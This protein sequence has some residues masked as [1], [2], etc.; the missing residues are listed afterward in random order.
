MMGEPSTSCSQL[1][2]FLIDPKLRS[3]S[4]QTMSGESAGAFSS[5]LKTSGVKFSFAS[6]ASAST[7]N[8]RMS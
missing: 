5:W 4:S 6:A 3:V 8:N 7:V 1:S 2:S